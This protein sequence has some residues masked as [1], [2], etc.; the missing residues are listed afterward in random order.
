[1]NKIIKN[2]FT[3]IEL[4]VVIAIIGILSGLIVVS[5]SG[6]TSKANVAKSQ[7]F[8]NSLKNSLMLNLVSE[9]KFDG[10]GADAWGSNPGNITGSVTQTSGCVQGSC[11][12]FDGNDFV[13]ILDSSSIDFTQ[14]MT[15]AVWAKVSDRTV[16]GALISKTEGGAFNISISPSSYPNEIASY[17]CVNGSY[18]NPR[19]SNTLI[20]NDKWFYIAITYDGSNGKI[21]L[22]GKSM[23]SV[24]SVGNLTPTNTDLYIGAESTG[25]AG[26]PTTPFLIGWVDEVRLFDAAI[27]AFQIKEQYYAG[28][29]KM[30]NSGNISR[31]EYISRIN[32]IAT[33]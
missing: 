14:Y 33:R 21:Y 23:N 7:V 28:L 8:A 10:D 29:N 27:P 13:R 19:F 5:M 24:P 2:A 18:I 15:V 25:I 11:L 16:A 32:S 4:L 6:V 1:M 12:S 30:L 22:D 31:E 17:I 20:S 26:S 3:L 9:Y